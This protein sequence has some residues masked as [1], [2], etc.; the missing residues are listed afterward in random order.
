MTLKLQ[1]QWIARL[2]LRAEGDKIRAEGDK[3]RAEGNKLRAEGDKLWAEAILSVYGNITLK[4]GYVKNTRTCTLG[5]GE[6]YRE[7]MKIEEESR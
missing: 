4:W 7:D 1:T 5:N 3:L 2:K 6:V